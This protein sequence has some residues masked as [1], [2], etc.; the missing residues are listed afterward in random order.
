MK[1]RPTEKNS[2]EQGCG[3]FPVQAATDGGYRVGF[4]LSC[5]SSLP[6]SA[7]HVVPDALQ[8]SPWVTEMGVDTLTLLSLLV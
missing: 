3:Q 5:Q 4:P 7:A 8:S 1:E 2:P 6:L